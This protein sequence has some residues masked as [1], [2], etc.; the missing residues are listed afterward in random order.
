MTE[1]VTGRQIVS[2]L[3][4]RW[5][6]GSWGVCRCPAHDDRSPSLS[7]RQTRDV[8]LVHCFAGC[9]Q[10]RV[11]EALRSQGLWP[12]RTEFGHQ[13]RPQA[14]LIANARPERDEDELANERAARASWF[15]AK[16]VEERS[17]AWLYLWWRGV[18]P[19]RIPPSLRFAEELYCH[20]LRRS[21]PALVAAVQDIDGR[22]SAIQ[23]I[24]LTRRIETVGGEGPAKGNRPALTAPKKTLGPMGRGAVRLGRAGLTL[25]IAE[26]IETGLAVRKLYSL[27][28]WV[29]LGTSRMGNLALPEVVTRVVIFG[30]NGEAGRKAADRA[31]DAYGEQGL[32]ADAEFP[33]E[34]HSDF[35]DWLISRSNLSAVA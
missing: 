4:G 25:G 2:A 7:V 35:A 13:A 6:P 22:V 3:K 24:W 15:A 27:P 28:V 20:E 26:G 9:P 16:L 31:V 19:R 10:D 5:N 21:L 8:V 34:E 11:I 17:A 30:D 23:R 33:P 1:Y 32:I 14:P 12:G 29:S 18:L